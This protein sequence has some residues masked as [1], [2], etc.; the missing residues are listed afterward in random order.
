MA[1]FQ[2][3]LMALTISILL[4]ACASQIKK[5]EVAKIR[6]VAVIGFD[7]QQQRSV[8][9]NDLLGIALGKQH[10][11]KAIVKL[12]NES[13][14]VDPMLTN[15]QK[16][17]GKDLQWVVIPAGDV[18]KNSRYQD[19]YKKKTQ[20]FQNRPAVAERY[21]SFRAPGVL[22][23]WA[24]LTTEKE[25]LQAIAQ[26]LKVDALVVGTAQVHLNNSSLLASLVG[27]GEYKP[28]ADFS[29]ILIQSQSGDHIF[30]ASIQGPKIDEVE[31][32]TLGLADEAKLN[33][34]AQTAVDLSI[35]KMM[36]EIPK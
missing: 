17:L 27:K 14:H 35:E 33:K 15:L 8:S 16:S 29:L 36:K 6:R 7:L 32:N 13:A 21:D 12:A 4:S 30:T 34:L 26:D 22:D 31:K 28:S 9:G 20:G 1:H 2:K 18:K 11:D 5:E 25:V 23:S 24:I 10:D 19:L 3:I